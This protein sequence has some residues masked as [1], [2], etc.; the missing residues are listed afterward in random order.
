MTNTVKRQLLSISLT[1][2]DIDR[3]IIPEGDMRMFMGGRA[4]GDIILHRRLT[5]GGEPFSPASQ[6]GFCV[7]PLTGTHAIGSGNYIGGKKHE[8]QGQSR[9]R[10]R[11]G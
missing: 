8:T 7:G 3:D 4:L 1:T 10:Y 9:Y 2:Q 6:M 11:W 5:A